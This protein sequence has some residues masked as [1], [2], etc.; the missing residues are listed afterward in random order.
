MREKVEG[1]GP[2]LGMTGAGEWALPGPM[3]GPEQAPGVQQEP[4]QRLALAG[5]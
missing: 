2:E 5:P 1:M 3:L 4:E